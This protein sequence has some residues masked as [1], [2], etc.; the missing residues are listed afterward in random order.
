M[1]TH[2]EKFPRLELCWFENN[3]DSRSWGQLNFSI[4]RLWRVRDE[5]ESVNDETDVALALK[6]VGYHVENYLNHVY[7]LRERACQLL[8]TI[9]NEES[10]VG[11]LKKPD[12]RLGAIKDLSISAKLKHSVLE[13]LNVLQNDIDL[14]HKNTHGTYLVLRHCTGDD[15]FDLEDALH[16]VQRENP[17][18]FEHF[19]NIIH[20][21]VQ[22][23]VAKFV[24]K[25]DHVQQLVVKIL[26]QQPPHL[27]AQ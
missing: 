23:M 26:R 5:L 22:Q 21:E 20:C 18:Q 17:E 3:E 8:T 2:E 13:L 16:D 12:N 19:E 15:D 11:K 7:E 9:T 10:L 27:R 25:I 1:V 6:R 24:A 4:H 14:R